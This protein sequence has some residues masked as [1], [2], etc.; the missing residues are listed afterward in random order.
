MSPKTYNSA[1]SDKI[2]VLFDGVCNLCNHA[3]NFIIDRDPS[4]RFLFSSLQSEAGRELL[5]K[6]QLDAQYLDSLVFIRGEKVY[7]KSTAALHI[8]RHLSGIWPLCYIFIVVP[9]VIRDF[10]YDI[11]ARFRYR[12]FG[13]SNHCRIPTPELKSRFLL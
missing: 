4:Q 3:V 10:F 1:T 13:R 7:L 8:A 5:K 9:P 6:H 2:I 11:V 12:V